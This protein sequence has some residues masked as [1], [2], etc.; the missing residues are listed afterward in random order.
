VLAAI[1]PI[2]EPDASKPWWKNLRGK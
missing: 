2:L 1:A